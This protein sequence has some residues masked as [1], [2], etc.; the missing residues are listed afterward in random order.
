M[1]EID[2]W[3]KNFD[4]KNII[5]N[6]KR[7]I[8]N[9]NISEGLVVKSLEKNIG[10]FLK[11]KYVLA[12]P[13]GSI[14]ILM[15]LIS[16]KLKRDDEV[17]IPDRAWISTLNAINI[18]GLKAKFVDVENS[19]PVID[20]NKLEKIINSKTKVIIAVHM[21]GRLCNMQQISRLAKKKIFL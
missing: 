11:S 8:F 21:G 14:A 5:F 9:K 18:L 19:I 7:N 6:L 17:I 1:F 20:C 4:N 2:Y 13:N 10:T 16:L 15:A 12:V 3:K